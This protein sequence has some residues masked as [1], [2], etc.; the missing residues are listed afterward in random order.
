MD[1][2]VEICCG[3]Y[4]DCIRAEEGGAT[5]VEL[6]SALF[7]GGLTPSMATVKQVVQDTN[8]DVICMV[9]PR[10]AGFCYSSEEFENMVMDAQLFLEQGVSGIAFGFLNE[11]FE[12]DV[13]ETK[14][15]VQLIHK[16]H[17][18]AVFHRAFDCV[19]DPQQAMHTLVDLGVDRV[20]T[21]GC[22]ETAPL[23]IDVLK[24]LQQTYG[25]RI[26]LLAGCGVNASNAVQLMKETGIRQVHSSCKG[27]QKDPTTIGANAVSYAYAPDEHKNCFDIV[28]QDKVEEL[29]EVVC[30]N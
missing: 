9:R 6:N 5:R 21:S 11:A 16:F 14:I 10:A 1:C 8:L 4:E 2:K 13:E 29:L 25:D 12:I 28:D 15:M 24:S 23:G 20:L 19:K 3:S 26:E 7:L 17:K 30:S 22:A 18:E 27:W